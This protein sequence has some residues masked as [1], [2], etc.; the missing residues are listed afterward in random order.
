MGLVPNRLAVGALA[1]AATGLVGATPAQAA[2]AWIEQIQND[3]TTHLTLRSNDPTW[4]PV[5]EGRQYLSDVP[6]E[7]PPGAHLNCS[8]FVIPWADYGRL[9]I[10]GSGPSVVNWTVGP[11]SDGQD[12]LKGFTNGM[13]LPDSHPLG[14]RGNQFVAPSFRYKL[15]VTDKGV[16]WVKLGEGV[17]RHFFEWA[18]LLVEAIIRAAAG[19]GGSSTSGR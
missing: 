6:I 3:S 5:C 15:H 17:E 13:K 11:K 18:R 12:Y 14:A 16:R 8:Y 7:V 2:M 19:S 1:L 4:H 9:E 10:R